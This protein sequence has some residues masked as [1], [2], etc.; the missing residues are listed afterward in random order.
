MDEDSSF[1]PKNYGGAGAGRSMPDDGIIQT[2]KKKQAN[3]YF[4]SDSKPP[5]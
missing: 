2:I 1:N 3:D 4:Q 5:I